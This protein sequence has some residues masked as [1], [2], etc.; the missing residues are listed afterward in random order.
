[1]TETEDPAENI[2]CSDGPSL[3]LMGVLGLMWE[4]SLEC[5]AGAGVC[6]ETGTRSWRSC[7]PEGDVGGLVWRVLGCRGLGHG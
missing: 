3:G 4:G 2:A 5:E 6:R 7:Q 1:M